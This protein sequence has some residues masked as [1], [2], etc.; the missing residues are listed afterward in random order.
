MDALAA[1]TVVVLTNGARAYGLGN[2]ARLRASMGVGRSGTNAD[3]RVPL[4][5]PGRI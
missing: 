2:A 1:R 3:D 5:S 4:A